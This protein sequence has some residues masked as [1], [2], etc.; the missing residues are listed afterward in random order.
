[1]PEN[2]GARGATDALLTFS[3]VVIDAANQLAS[4][5]D[6]TLDQAYGVIHTATLMLVNGTL[7]SKLE[8]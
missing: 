5:S 7:Y 1:M 4:E 8:K 6:L 3:R 2:E